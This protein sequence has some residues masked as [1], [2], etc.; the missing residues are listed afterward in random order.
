M[1]PHSAL[2]C[3]SRVTHEKWRGRTL[4]L[5]TWQ[6]TSS[7]SSVARSASS[8]SGVMTGVVVCVRCS[9]R[10]QSCW[11]T[12]ARREAEICRHS[13]ALVCHTPS[14]VGSPQAAS[15]QV[16]KQ[17]GKRQAGWVHASWR[18]GHAAITDEAAMS[19]DCSWVAAE[20]MPDP[21]CKSCA[22]V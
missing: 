4:S 13:V 14:T 11:M 16:Q 12:V 21:K 15:R 19:M 5:L 18:Q 3:A 10:Y 2:G 22:G 20:S 8:S 9:V 1:G 7:T 17:Q 6:H